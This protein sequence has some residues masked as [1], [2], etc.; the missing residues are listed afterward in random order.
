LHISGNNFSRISLP[1]VDFGE[2][3]HKGANAVMLMAQCCPGLIPNGLFNGRSM[4]GMTGRRR[5][6]MSCFRTRSAPRSHA[7][8][9]LAIRSA[10]V[11]CAAR[12]FGVKFWPSDDP[13]R[14]AVARS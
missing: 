9:E 6:A 10:Q 4:A 7:P 14:A 11:R 1:V 13:V 3:S 8:A 5:K 12:F 2:F